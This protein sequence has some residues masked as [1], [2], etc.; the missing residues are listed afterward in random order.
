LNLEGKLVLAETKKRKMEH[1]DICI[2]DKVQARSIHTGFDDVHLIHRALPETSLED[3]DTSTEIFGYELA[4]PIVIEAMTGGTE[5]AAKINEALAKAAE[6]FKIA[7]GVGSQRVALED[8]SLEYTFRVARDNAPRA[9]LIA[10]LGASEILGKSSLANIEKAIKMIDADAFAIHLN[11]LQ[12]AMQPEGYTSF[13]RLL[14]NIREVTSKVRIPVIAKETGAGIAFEEARLLEDAGVKGI[15]VGGAGGTSWAAVE[16]HRARLRMDKH[17]ERLGNVFWDWGIPTVVST[18]EVRHTTSLKVIASGGIRTG[19]DAAKALVLGADAVGLALPLLK[20]AVEGGLESALQMLISEL[21]TAMFLVGA[22]SISQLKQSP[23]IITGKTGEW[24][25]A[26]G[27]KPEE[28]SR[29][30]AAA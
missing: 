11:S 17:R 19:V 4:A 23:L 28:Y 20:P 18:V 9:F 29:R 5:K 24:L 30:R 21:K 8:S 25:H 14:E 15:D 1:L 26:R 3:I 10:N 6:K 13:N 27:F 12:E 16:L 22:Q 2:K 7:L